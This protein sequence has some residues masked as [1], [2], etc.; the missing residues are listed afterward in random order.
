MT[1]TLWV[2]SICGI[3]LAL[4]ISCAAIEHDEKDTEPYHGWWSERNEDEERRI[5]VSFLTKEV[6]LGLIR[7][8]LGGVGM[9]L[10]SKGWVSDEGWGQ[11][12]SNFE[13]AAGA[14]IFLAAAVAS[15]LNKRKLAKTVP[16]D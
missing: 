12:M 2:M 10:M 7:H 9:Y 3:F 6:V 5:P 4:E 16:S 1:A 14:L 11:I 13:A 15:I 8:L